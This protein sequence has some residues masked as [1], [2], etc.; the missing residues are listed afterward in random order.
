[1]DQTPI[2]FTYNLRKTLEIVGRR[3]VH[4]RKSTNDTKRAMFTM[5][6]AASGKI[7]KPL[8]IFK[9][10]RNGCIVQREFPTYEN[11]MIYLCQA[12][13]WMDMEAMLVWIEQV[14][15]PHIE[16]APP[17]ILPI[18]FLDSY[19]CHMM[20][21]VVGK[22]QDLGVEVEHIPGGYTLICQ[23]V[24]IG[25]NKPFKNRLRQQWEEWMIEEGLANGTT[26]PP[27][28]EDIVRWTRYATVNLPSQIV[29]NAWRHGDYSWFPTAGEG[30]AHLNTE[31]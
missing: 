21:S 28:R 1:M 11:N 29:R 8:D 25:V 15:C 17:S 22:I 31:D 23:L 19:C 14:L 3:T 9:G 7:L 5:T 30:A 4:V 27:A 12:N 13:A 24:D 10:A 6:V 18:L 16:T 2:P 26:S 20:A